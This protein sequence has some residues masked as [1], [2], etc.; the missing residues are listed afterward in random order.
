MKK[1]IAG[2]AP[3]FLIAALMLAASSASAAP[4]DYVRLCDVAGQDFYYSPGT[5]V[6]VNAVTGS[7]Y[8]TNTGETGKTVYRAQADAAVSEAQRA[9]KRANTAASGVAI[10][11]AMPGAFITS[12]HNFALSGNASQFGGF[13][14]MGFGG[15]AKV[16]EKLSL[17]G[18]MGASMNDG[19]VGG[20]V[21][22]N[23]SW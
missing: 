14:S 3:K 16:S 8:D 18:G 11:A 22:F 4:V 21:G 7:T 2:Q 19:T 13:S 20:R 6:C 10:A 15:A 9:T 5:E 12:G 23:M 1:K 17:T